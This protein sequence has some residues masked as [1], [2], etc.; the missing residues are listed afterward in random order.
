M[1]AAEWF[2][3]LWLKMTILFGHCNCADRDY[4]KKAKIPV[5]GEV[6]P[7][8]YIHYIERRRG[9]RVD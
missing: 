9:W 4:V 7:F 3:L 5:A 2:A 8:E 6:V 1:T